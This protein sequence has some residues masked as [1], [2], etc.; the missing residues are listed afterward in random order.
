MYINKK[1]KS[2]LIIVSR[3]AIASLAGPQSMI[4]LSVANAHTVQAVRVERYGGAPLSVHTTTTT[5]TDHQLQKIYKT[6][7]FYL[8]VNRGAPA[9]GVT[10]KS[11]GCGF[12]PH[13]RR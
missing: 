13:S 8:E 1:V 4:A 3:V 7:K 10:I 2:Y 11:T 9:R 6:I 12:D 5:T